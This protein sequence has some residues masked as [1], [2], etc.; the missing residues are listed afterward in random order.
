MLVSSSGLQAV[1]HPGRRNRAT[2]HAYVVG[3]VLLVVLIAVA[4][5]VLAGP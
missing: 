1:R 3:V 4:A 5:L 2:A